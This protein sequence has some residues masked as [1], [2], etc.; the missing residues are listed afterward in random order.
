MKHTGI[1][2]YAINPIKSQQP[3]YGPIYTLE[4]VKLEIFKTYIKINLAIYFA[5]ASKFPTSAPIFFVLILIVVF[6]CV[7]ITEVL[8]I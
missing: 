6:G 2:K 7:L 5:R 4:T 8:T 3:F 1:N